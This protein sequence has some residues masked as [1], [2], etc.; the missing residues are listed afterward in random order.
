MKA[1]FVS[2]FFPDVT[3]D[4]VVTSLKEQLSLKKLVCTRLKTKFS[5]YAS[6]H[7]SVLEDEFPL[8]NNTGIWPAGCVIDPFYGKLTP[9]QI[10]SLSAP[11]IGDTCFTSDSNQEPGGSPDISQNAPKD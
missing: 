7:V 6:F 11:V 4:D 1:I 10:Y 8:I 5:T 9:D 3:T 2:R